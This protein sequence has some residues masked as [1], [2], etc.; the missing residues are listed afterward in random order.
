LLRLFY[1]VFRHKPFSGKDDRSS[2]DGSRGG[3][4]HGLQEGFLTASDL[5]NKGHGRKKF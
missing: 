4:A 3:N 2:N 5:K 1:H